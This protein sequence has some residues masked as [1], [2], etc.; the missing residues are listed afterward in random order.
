MKGGAETLVPEGISE[1]LHHD[2]AA[3]AIATSD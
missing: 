2:H 1:D 3:L